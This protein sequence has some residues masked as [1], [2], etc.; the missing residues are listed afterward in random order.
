MRCLDSRKVVV[1]EEEFYCA[2]NGRSQSIPVKMA[3]SELGKQSCWSVGHEGLPHILC[4]AVLGARRL[5]CWGKYLAAK[6][7]GSEICLRQ[8]SF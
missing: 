4:V 7:A 2:K 3:P 5:R 6:I 8:L 1:V